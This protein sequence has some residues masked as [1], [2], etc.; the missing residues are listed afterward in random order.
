MEHA[1]VWLVL[2]CVQHQGAGDSREMSYESKRM[3]RGDACVCVCAVRPPHER[4]Q[5]RPVP[6]SRLRLATQIIRSCT[7]ATQGGLCIE[8]HKKESSCSGQDKGAVDD[9]SCCLGRGSRV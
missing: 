5:A 4:P 3:P 1:A 7:P 8:V 9:G 2:G 6:S